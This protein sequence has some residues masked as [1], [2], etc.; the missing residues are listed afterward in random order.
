[1]TTQS[2]RPSHEP[3]FDLRRWIYVK[4]ADQ[5]HPLLLHRLDARLQ[6]LGGECQALAVEG[7]THKDVVG[8]A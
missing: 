4:L 3:V 1:M 5:S 7:G 2:L 8:P 6:F